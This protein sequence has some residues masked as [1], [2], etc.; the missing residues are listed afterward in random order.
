MSEDLTN[1]IEQKLDRVQ[2]DLA[3]LN[4][5]LAELR[6]INLRHDE[7][8][9]DNSQKIESLERNMHETQGAIR[10]GKIV[11]MSVL[12]CVIGVIGWVVNREQNKDDYVNMLK[13]Q[14]LSNRHF[15][16]LQDERIRELSIKLDEMKRESK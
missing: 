13:E 5:N 1:R 12:S 4:L 3:Q 2:V 9:R 7:L 14:I 11:T 15:N 16:E 6:A 8:S 10:L